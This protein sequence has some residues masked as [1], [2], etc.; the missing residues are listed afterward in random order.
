[1]PTRKTLP[2]PPEIL[3]F[4]CT[5]ELEA[6]A[7][8]SAGG[9]ALPRFSMVAY[10]GGAMQLGG[11]GHPTVISLDGMAIPAQR[12]P[13]RFNHSSY[14][15]VGHTERIAV[16][17]GRLVAEGVVSR[18]TQAAKEIIASGK[19]GFPWQASIGASADEVEFIKRDVSV[20]VNGRQF[21]G[22]LYVVHKARLNEISF[23]D[24][25]ADQQTQARIAAKEPDMAKARISEDG[26]VE[27]QDE[28]AD[29]TQG[30]PSQQGQTVQARQGTATSDPASEIEGIV[31][32]ARAESARR[33]RIQDIT[34]EALASRPELVDSIDRLARNAIEAGRT[35][36]Q[37]QLDV[38][39]ATR[40]FGGVGGPR[41]QDH[42]TDGELV[43]AALCMAGGLERN[44]LE[45]QFGEQTLEAAGRQYRHGLGLQE[46]LLL[47]AHQNG[48]R[49]FG[50]SDPRGLLRA[51]FADGEIQAAGPSTLSLPGI[52]SNV[53][54]KFL[55]AGF[56]AVEGTWREIS[57]RRPVRDFKQVSSYTLT[58]DFTY[59]QVAPG[60][61]LEHATAGEQ[62]YTNKADTYGRMFAI[63]R[64]D[65]INDDLDA[66]T[67]IPR[68]LGR[69]A[70]LKLNEVFWNAF[71]DNAAFFAAGN[72][73]YLSGAGTAFGI[74]SL[75][76]AEQ[77]FLD[78]TDPDGKPLAVA[79][80][81]LLVPNG[82]YVP[83]TQ[84]MN[85]TELRDTTA[86]KKY[87]TSN[88]HAGK[89]AV[90]RSSYLSN[91]AFT[92]YSALA[93]YLLA[94]PMDMPVIE[95][96]FLNGQEQPT[97]E[98]AEADFNT[99]G[100]QMRGYHDFGVSKQEPRGGVKMKGE[101]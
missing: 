32:S 34:A 24:L 83:A 65:I 48:Y 37:F 85:S 25:G 52:L 97:V 23:V 21:K 82:L 43:E 5:V 69:G 90:V 96:A 41:R 35:S 99:L 9:E 10:T 62:S 17:D 58:G 87:A 91:A 68:R 64:R 6:A 4:D 42:R 57:A 74:D 94:D 7:P 13:V 50:R 78:Q 49:G 53:A 92:G 28:S 72:N 38:M 33:R 14:E 101:A 55:R 51:A 93:W 59:K 1:M 2:K 29:A 56:E 77:L 80:K 79:P 19:R 73:N 95:V 86:S 16:E 3:A 70:G 47:F 89:F 88:P 84:V 98:T 45:A 76:S 15:G 40:D 20:T 8:E 81:V 71:M 31:A 66:L 11:W 36:E 60:G 27:A 22:P 12:R 61:E 44:I 30:Q 18:D 67:A 100:I 39:R 46:T 54:N 26:V 63:D 75:T